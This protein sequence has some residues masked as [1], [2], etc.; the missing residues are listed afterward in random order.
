MTPQEV[1]DDMM[2]R[3][4]EVDTI[5]REGFQGDSDAG[6][7]HLILAQTGHML[8]IEVGVQ[9]NGAAYAVVRLFGPNGE[10]L[11]PQVLSLAGAVMAVTPDT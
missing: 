11:E 6:I 10:Q 2:T 7:G 1:Y 4:W 5:E 8:A 9:V 3:C